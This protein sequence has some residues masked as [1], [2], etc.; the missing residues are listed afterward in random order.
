MIDQAQK[1]EAIRVMITKLQEAKEP[2]A[3]PR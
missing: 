1:D 3:V 2:M